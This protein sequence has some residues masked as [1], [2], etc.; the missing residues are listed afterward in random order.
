MKKFGLFFGLCM[1]VGGGSALATTVTLDATSGYTAA[2]N[3][4]ALPNGWAEYTAVGNSGNSTGSL[5]FN[6]SGANS[7]TLSTQ[8]GGGV[9]TSAQLSAFS[10][11]ANGWGTMVEGNSTTKNAGE[12]FGVNYPQANPTAWGVT[13]SP[14]GDAADALNLSVTANGVITN[15]TLD[16]SYRV[17]DEG[18]FQTETGPLYADLPGLFLYYSVNGGAWTRAQNFD[19]NTEPD[20]TE[21]PSNGPVTTQTNGFVWG[22]S[23]SGFTAAENTAYPNTA[24]GS[25]ESFS[26]TLPVSLNNGDNLQLRWFED[27][28]VPSS[29]EANVAITAV[30]IVPAAVPEPSTIALCLAGSAGLA[31]AGLRRKRQAV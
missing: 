18:T 2:F 11:G 27:N 15:P 10:L 31:V 16:V 5:S 4:T 17:V 19:S 21:N 29:P 1:L 22:D 6:A 30:S 12:A 26:A 14:T 24:V 3:G 13:V 28:S 25:Q 23:K 7:G 20:L 9:P 8:Y